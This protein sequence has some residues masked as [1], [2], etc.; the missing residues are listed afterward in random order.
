MNEGK[1]ELMS[2]RGLCY[3]IG[4]EGVK[5][6]L[7]AGKKEDKK[8]NGFLEY[9]L[10]ITDVFSQHFTSDL[11][12][13]IICVILAITLLATIAGLVFV[14]LIAFGFKKKGK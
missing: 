5:T 1:G 7:A 11:M 8:M 2:A 3:V 9:I 13:N 4:I 14:A 6:I 12:I 10:Y